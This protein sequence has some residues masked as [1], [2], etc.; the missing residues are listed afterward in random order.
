MSN[1]FGVKYRLTSF[2]ESHG[3]AIGGIIDGC[4]SNFPL[5][6]EHI[7]TELD[8]RRPGKSAITSSR[9]EKDKVEF[10]S[11]VYEGKTLGTPIA[12]VVWN[13]NQKGKDYDN[14]KDIYRPSHADYT[15]HKKYGLRDHRGGGRASARETVSRVVAGAIAKQL[16]DVYNIE[17]F[18]Y[19]SQIGDIKL[20]ENYYQNV[21]TDNILNCPDEKIANKMIAKIAEFKKAGDSLGGTI[22]CLIK[23]VPVGLGEPVFNKFNAQLSKAILGINACKGFEI[24]A[25]FESANMIGSQNNDIF[26][27]ENGK[28]KTH[29]NNSGGVQ[30]GITNGEDVY[31]KAVFKPVPTILK[32]QSTITT[33][34]KQVE[35]TA[36]GRHDPSVL[37]RALPIVEAMTAM[38]ALDFILLNK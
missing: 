20:D 15:Y 18:A 38:V 1:T 13:N 22:N 27:F 2:G 36:K 4:P 8:K 19:V 6:F 31:F 30:G 25:G 10:L 26:Y 28:I 24:G 5:D 37:P 23:N 16:L 34:C 35:Y 12:F 33:D 14:L 21:K 11:G 32:T 3:K 29:T 17:I 7:Q 9:N